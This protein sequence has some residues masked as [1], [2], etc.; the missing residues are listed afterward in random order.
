MHTSVGVSFSCGTR[1]DGSTWCWGQCDQAWG[2]P[3]SLVQ[4]TSDPIAVAPLID[5]RAVSAGH[6]DVCI[7]DR[8]TQLWCWGAN[9]F[10]Q[11]GTGDFEPRGEPALVCVP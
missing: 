6:L 5:A 2:C 11:L 1:S 7:I 9:S 10:G 8:L 3:G 4:L